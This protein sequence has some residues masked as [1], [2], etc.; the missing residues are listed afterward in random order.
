MI[1]KTNQLAVRATMEDTPAPVPLTPEKF[2]SNLAYWTIHGG[3]VRCSKVGAI[4]L[5][6]M[7]YPEL[8][9]KEAKELCDGLHWAI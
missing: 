9:L 7:Q 4:K 5:V 8:D 2:V 1:T 6:R 3:G